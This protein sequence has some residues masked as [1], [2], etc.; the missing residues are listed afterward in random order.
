MHVLKTPS[1]SSHLP[2]SH[3]S[4]LA[5]PGAASGPPGLGHGAATTAAHE[6]YASTAE[7]KLQIHLPIR[8]LQYMYTSF[9]T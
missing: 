3:G 4:L 2:D 9:L 5:V 1:P 6:A 7:R 8:S